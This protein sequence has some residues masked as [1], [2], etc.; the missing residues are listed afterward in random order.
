MIDTDWDL[1][2]LGIWNIPANIN[3][4]PEGLPKKSIAL[5][6]DACQGKWLSGYRGPKPPRELV[7]IYIDSGICFRYGA[8]IEEHAGKNQLQR[9]WMVYFNMEY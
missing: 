3:Y 8:K 9:L 1:H 7:P 4:I 5:L 6:G 2:S